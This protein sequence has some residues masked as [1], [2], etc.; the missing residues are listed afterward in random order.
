MYANL[1]N[2]QQKF[3]IVTVN[4]LDVDVLRQCRLHDFAQGCHHCLH[5][6][7]VWLQTCTV[8]LKCM[9]SDTTAVSRRQWAVGCCV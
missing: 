3:H 5:D 9:Q 1:Y 7:S 4:A 2:P 8:H 6:A